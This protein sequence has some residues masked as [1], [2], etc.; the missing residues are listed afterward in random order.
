MEIRN[1]VVEWS[2]NE[3]LGFTVG[4]TANRAVC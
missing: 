1:T 3:Q 2:E 4:A